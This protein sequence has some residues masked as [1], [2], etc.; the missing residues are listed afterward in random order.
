LFLKLTRH[1][2]AQCRVDAFDVVDVVEDTGDLPLSVG[3]VV[4]VGEINL[5]FY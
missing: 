5:L 1:Q 3:E 2:V 4:V